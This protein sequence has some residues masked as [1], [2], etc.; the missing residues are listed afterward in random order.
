[1]HVS[2]NSKSR[3]QKCPSPAADLETQIRATIAKPNVIC[4][5]WRGLPP[6]TGP[7]FLWVV[8]AWPTKLPRLFL[9]FLNAVSLSSLAA[10]CQVGVQVQYEEPRACLRE[11]K[12]SYRYSRWQNRLPLGKQYSQSLLKTGVPF[13][14]YIWPPLSRRFTISKGGQRTIKYHSK[15]CSAKILLRVHRS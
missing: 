3:I 12:D 11:G 14:R 1:V 8:R 15:F 4:L 10:D 5:S 2:A 7:W 9:T 13:I 6:A